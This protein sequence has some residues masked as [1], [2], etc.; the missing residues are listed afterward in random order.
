MSHFEELQEIKKNVSTIH[1]PIILF[2]INQ[3][4]RHLEEKIKEVKSLK[5]NFELI[6]N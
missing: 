3:K 2:A 4:V 1:D 5:V 6:K